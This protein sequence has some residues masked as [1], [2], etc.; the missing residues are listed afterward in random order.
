MPDKKEARRSL[1]AGRAT[2]RERYTGSIPYADFR[3]GS[4]AVGGLF[5]ICMLSAFL[6]EVMGL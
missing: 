1:A 6:W 2:Y 4:Y 3:R 5:A